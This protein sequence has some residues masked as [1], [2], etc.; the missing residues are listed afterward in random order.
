[1]LRAIVASQIRK[2]Y[3]RVSTARFDELLAG[4]AGDAVF[5]MMGEHELGGERRGKAAIRAWFDET[6]RLFP[7]LRIEPIA[8][9]A[10]GPPWNMQ[11]ATRFRVSASLAGG[12]R[13]ENEGMQFL[14]LRW[15]KVVEDRLF[16]DTQV[17]RE[18]I[19][20]Q[21]AAATSAA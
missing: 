1:M 6:H 19:E 7:D 12:G 8:V 16:E 4:F 2:G 5:Q 20:H 14:R 18:A 15:A 3:E 9:V 17:L 11:A 10:S 13:Y 21:R